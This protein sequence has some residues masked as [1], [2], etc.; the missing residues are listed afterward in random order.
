M[1]RQLARFTKALLIGLADATTW[2]LLIAQVALPWMCAPPRIDEDRSNNPPLEPASDCESIPERLFQTWKCRDVLPLNYAHWQA[3]FRTQNPQFACTLWDDD[4][5]RRFIEQHYPWFLPTYDDYPAEIFRADMVRPFY[6]FHFGGLYADM[7]TQCLRPLSDMLKGH[8]I[9]L[10]RMGSNPKFPDSIPNAIMASRP[11]EIFW[12]LMIAMAMD[13]LSELTAANDD[14]R[15]APEAFTGPRLLRETY[16][17]YVAS[18][19]AAIRERALPV[20]AQIR[21]KRPL[22]CS[23]VTLLSRDEWYPIDWSNPVHVAFRHRLN[24]GRYLLSE[25]ALRWLFPNASLVTF[26]TR[27]WGE[28]EQN[29][30]RDT[31]SPI[32]SGST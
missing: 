14:L 18:D 15:F 23:T 4:D 24:R 10:G 17:F 6:L 11:G 9:A 29:H 22:R 3:S 19:E 26:W 16:E 5:N 8:H 2:R 13:K 28:T 30:D 1:F 25:T 31:D 12:L 21:Q 20:S 7:D 27:S 32:R